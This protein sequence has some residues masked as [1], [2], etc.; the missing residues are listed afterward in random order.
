MIRS[1][2]GGATIAAIAAVSVWF[3]TVAAQNPAPATG[4]RAIA[5]DL[6]APGIDNGLRNDPRPVRTA[7]ETFVRAGSDNAAYV[8]GSLIVKFR[9]GTTPA[10]QQALLASIEGQTTTDL[11]YTDFDIV[12]LRA[13]ADPEALARRL[14][15]Q[16]DVDYAQARYRVRPAFVPN[17]PLYGEQWNY[18]TLDME[19]A[20][21]I[22]PG[23][24]SSLIV[25]VLDSGIAYRNITLRFETFPTLI[26]LLSGQ[27]PLLFPSLGTIDVPFAAAPELGGADRFVTPRDFIWDDTTPVDMDGHGTHV[28]GIVGQLTNNSVGVAG[29]A[30][31]VRLMP[32]KVIDGFW[33]AYFGSPFVGTD[34]VVARGIRYAVDNGARVL[35]MSIGR[36]GP[37]APVVQEAIAYAVSRGAFVAVAGGNDFREGNPVERLAEFAPQINGMVSVAAVGRDSAKAIYSST[38]AYI[39]LSAPGGDASR[40]GATSAILQ[41]TYDLNLVETFLNGPSRLRAP[42]FDVFAY[43]RFQGTSMAAPHVSGLAAMLMQQGITDPAAIEA[44]MKRYATDLGASGRD[45]E[46]GVGLINP[47]ASLRGMG[48][49]R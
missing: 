36:S 10:V 6:A 30:F 43:E 17:D 38:G 19:R 9:A 5:T 21:D 2:C 49:V 27:P 39:E 45:D 3:A 47:R 24:A 44:A 28:S 11:S 20:W 40:G 8:R 13:D 37:P 25:A 29:M 16:P 34:D 26:Q 7:A 14:Q 42:R 41:Q 48:V 18:R 23:A 33:D 46:Y 15:A 35:N 4:T 12:A 22:N 1:N 32:V 31:N